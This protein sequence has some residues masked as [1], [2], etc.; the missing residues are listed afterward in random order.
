M[1]TIA[2]EKVFRKV[3][4]LGPYK[5]GHL[6][7]YKAT[8]PKFESANDYKVTHPEK[9]GERSDAYKVSRPKLEEKISF[10]DHLFK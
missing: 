10:F 7:A 4:T 2:S 9:F 6:R 3:K 1:T 5:V 8:H